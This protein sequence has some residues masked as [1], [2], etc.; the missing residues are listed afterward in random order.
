MAR[1]ECS[2]GG[3]P[4]CR[5]LAA[6]SASSSVPWSKPAECHLVALWK[7]RQNEFS[8]PNHA[9][10]ETGR[11]LSFAL[12]QVSIER[13]SSELNTLSQK[14]CAPRLEPEQ[15]EPDAEDKKLG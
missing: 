4:A 13:F 5:L 7:L 1:N 11:Q 12:L 10:I 3:Q 15:D 6:T 9:N 8:T 2:G 14:V